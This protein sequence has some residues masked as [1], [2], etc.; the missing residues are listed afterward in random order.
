MLNFNLMRAWQNWFI[1]FLMIT[2]GL[3][4]SHIFIELISPDSDD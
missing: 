1:I 4:G 3:T 2:I